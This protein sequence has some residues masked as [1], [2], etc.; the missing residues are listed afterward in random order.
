MADIIVA[1]SPPQSSLSGL[2]CCK[3]P[4]GKNCQ[5]NK[6]TS[7]IMLCL[8]G[9]Y[10]FFGLRNRICIGS[11]SFGTKIMISGPIVCQLCKQEIRKKQGRSLKKVFQVTPPPHLFFLGA[12]GLL[13]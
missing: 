11:F 4:S 3:L 7:M 2:Y 8:D 9:T 12:A 10:F 6:H 13:H 1:R 5:H